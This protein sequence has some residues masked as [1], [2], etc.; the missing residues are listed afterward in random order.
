[1]HFSDMTKC[2]KIQNNLMYKNDSSKDNCA[3]QKQVNSGFL[4]RCCQSPLGGL[5]QWVQKDMSV[6]WDWRILIHFA[7]FFFK[8]LLLS[9]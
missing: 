7:C 3:F 9:P 2:R 6:D 5:F 1:M 4:F 8:A